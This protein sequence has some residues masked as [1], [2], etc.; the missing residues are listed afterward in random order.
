MDI[1]GIDIGPAI[2]PIYGQGA[3][4]VLTGPHAFDWKV[5]IGGQLQNVDFIRIVQMQ[6]GPRFRAIT[7]GAGANDWAAIDFDSARNEVLPVVIVAFEMFDKIDMVRTAVDRYL[8]NIRMAQDWY[9]T[10]LGGRTFRVVDRAL[11]IRSRSSGDQWNAW[12]QLTDTPDSVPKPP[13]PNRN[14]LLEEQ[15]GTIQRAFG[16]GIDAAPLVACVSNFT[17]KGRAASGAGALNRAHFCAITPLMS[18]IKGDPKNPLSFES[19][20]AVYT[21]GHELGHAFGLPHPSQR[22]PPLPANAGNSLMGNPTNAFGN[23]ILMDV[24]KREL[25]A[26]PFIG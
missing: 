3:E 16:R 9:R 6:H 10:Q 8:H 4:L 1:R 18:E 23:A 13:I 12:A 22:P 11:V 5:R 15:A 25:L 19:V 21:I 7:V 14:R 26:S 2:K 17:G 24:E 20:A